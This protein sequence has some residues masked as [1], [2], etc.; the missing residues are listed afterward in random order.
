MLFQDIIS[1]LEKFWKKRGCLIGI[2]YP[3]DVGAGTFNP[4]TFFTVLDRQPAKIAYIETSKRP[5]DGRY[6]KNPNRLQ[7]FFQYQV[8][9][10]PAP[11]NIQDIYLSS[12]ASLGIRI[13]SHDI[14]FVEDDWEQ[15]TLSAYGLGWEVWLDGMEIT[16][17]TYFQ[18]MAGIELEVIPV[19]I[20]YGLERICM[21]LQEKDSVFDI[22][23]SSNI[24]YGE[25][26]KK[27]EEEFSRFNFEEASTEILRFDFERYEKE[28]K[29][30][31]EVGLLFPTYDYCIKCSHILN[32]LDAR[33]AL[34]PEERKNLM[35]R[36]RKLTGKVGER[37]SDAD[38]RFG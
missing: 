10:K 13:K 18:R 20:T 36:I 19:E 34:S 9:V 24:R 27:R 17:F 1:G 25:L 12:L 5:K 22:D 23:W 38:Y 7:A 21:L 33:R 8:I 26:F 28:A 11:H 14:R 3:G 32:L 6:G 16:Q 37:I 30:L 29:R 35:A 15:E 2:P 4:L 31:F